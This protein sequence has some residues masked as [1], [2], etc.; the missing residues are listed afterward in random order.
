ML[1]CRRVETKTQPCQPAAY[2]FPYLRGIL[3]DAAS[4]HHAIQA[5]QCC[6]KR[7]DLALSPMYEQVDRLRRDFQ[8]A[9]R[10]GATPIVRGDRLIDEGA[11][12]GIRKEKAA[13]RSR[14]FHQASIPQLRRSGARADAVE[15]KLDRR[16]TGIDDQQCVGPG[17]GHGGDVR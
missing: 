7:S 9:C 3:A 11:S 6:G 14:L 10:A 1:I 4:K 13:L 8:Q 5:A 12:T 15:R 2:A 16:R 17:M